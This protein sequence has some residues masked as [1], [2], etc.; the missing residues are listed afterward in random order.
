[1]HWDDVY[2]QLMAD[3]VILMYEMDRNRLSTFDPP[4]A[5]AN[6]GGIVLMPMDGDGD[7]SSS[8]GLAGVRG[9]RLGRR[10]SAQRGIAGWVRRGDIELMARIPFMPSEAHVIASAEALGTIFFFVATEVGLS[11][12]TSRQGR[13]AR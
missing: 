7:G 12:S 3:D 8:L 11:R 9:S 2:F 10:V 5:H 1:M 6:E 4:A 13:S